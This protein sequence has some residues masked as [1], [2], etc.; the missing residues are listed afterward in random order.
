MV[1]KG[2]LFGQLARFIV[3]VNSW[4]FRA[5]SELLYKINRPQVSMV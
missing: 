5:S 3:P 2:F 4:K 1:R